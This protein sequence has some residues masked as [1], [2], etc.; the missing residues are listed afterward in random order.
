[1]ATMPISSPA[2]SGKELIMKKLN[3]AVVGAT[4][5]VGRTFLKVLEEEKLPVENYYLFASA[6]SAGS[7][8][9]FMGKPHEVI[10]LAEKNIVDKKIGFTAY[11]HE[12]FQKFFFLFAKFRRNLSEI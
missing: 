7:I 1:M 3:V 9:D 4:G 6:K 2:F 8:I 11:T 5:M 12:L 10:E